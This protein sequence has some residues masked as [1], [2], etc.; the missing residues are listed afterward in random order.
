MQETEALVH[1]VSL[2]QN[3]CQHL[4]DQP[5]ELVTRR[6]II[7]NLNPQNRRH[8]LSLGSYL[9]L[10]TSIVYCAKYFTL[11]CLFWCFGSNSYIAVQ[12]VF[13]PSTVP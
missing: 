8:S 5:A 12:Y 7:I 1:S 2:M 6:H 13:S 4:Y 10:K 11:Y 3:H 9:Q